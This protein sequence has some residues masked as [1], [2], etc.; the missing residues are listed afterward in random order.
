MIRFVCILLA[1]MA[2]L[3]CGSNRLAEEQDPLVP[4]G[5]KAIPVPPSDPRYN[6]F[7]SQRL[8]FTGKKA[9]AWKIYGKRNDLVLKEYKSLELSFVT[10]LVR[11]HTKLGEIQAATT[12]ARTLLQWADSN[13]Q[14]HSTADRGNLRLAYANIRFVKEEYPV[15]RALYD[16]IR[17]TAEFR[18]TLIQLEAE[19]RIAEITRLMMDFDL[20]TEQLATL[21]NHADQNVKVRALFQL[22]L[23]YHDQTDYEEALKYTRKGLKLAPDYV[24]LLLLE[25]KIG[26]KIRARPTV[27]P[28]QPPRI[29]VPGRRFKL[30]FATGDMGL[31]AMVTPVEVRVWTEPGGDEEFSRLFPFSDNIGKFVGIIMTELGTAKKHDGTLQVLKNDKVFYDFSEAFKEKHHIRSKAPIWSAVVSNASTK[32]DSKKITREVKREKK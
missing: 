28:Y 7:K 29:V 32:A 12:L 27:R 6:V 5:V 21:A 13:P 24:D 22:A 30:Y 26:L 17:T 23:V 18:H 1:C 16:Q 20:A 15:A 9:S 8:Y 3:G 4:Q 10:W 2:T 14:R 11:R 19:L 31:A 25:G